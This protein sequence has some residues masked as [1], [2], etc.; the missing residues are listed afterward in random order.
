VASPHMSAIYS[1][2]PP[3]R[4]GT[5]WVRPNARPANA[6]AN[7][8]ERRHS[9]IGYLK[10]RGVRAGGI[11][12]GGCQPIRVQAKHGLLG[13]GVFGAENERLHIGH[14]ARKSVAVSGEI[15]D[16]AEESDTAN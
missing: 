15:G 10:S 7:H 12:L 14:A 6:K 1:A 3:S 11:S 5:T 8:P 9:T 13:S 16:L 4:Y 2:A